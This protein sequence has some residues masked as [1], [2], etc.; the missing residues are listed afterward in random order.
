MFNPQLVVM[1]F[2]QMITVRDKDWKLDIN[3][4]V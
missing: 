1:T 3:A 2:D 4:D